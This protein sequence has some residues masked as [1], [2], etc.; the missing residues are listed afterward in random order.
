MPPIGLNADTSIDLLNPRLQH[1]LDGRVSV[2]AFLGSACAPAVQGTNKVCSV[3][4]VTVSAELSD[5][6]VD[7][8]SMSLA[9]K[10]TLR[11]RRSSRSHCRSEEPP[12]SNTMAT[13]AWGQQTSLQSPQNRK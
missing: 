5:N 4:V 13:A 12:L 3:K 11:D 6:K 8:C 2:R 7:L 10:C 1:F 9:M